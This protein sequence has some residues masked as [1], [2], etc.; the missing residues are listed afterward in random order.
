MLYMEKS[1]ISIIIFECRYKLSLGKH[2][3]QCRHS[4]LYVLDQE[5]LNTSTTQLKS[6]V[7]LI[8]LSSGYMQAQGKKERKKKTKKQKTK[9]NV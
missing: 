9:E 6:R 8:D 7:L 4:I 1:P 2:F 3:L 5:R